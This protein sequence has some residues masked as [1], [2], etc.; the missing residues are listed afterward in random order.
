MQRDK[1]K[2]FSIFHFNL[3]YSSLDQSRIPE[4]I[5]RCYWPLLELVE[6]RYFPVGIEA[7][8]YTLN[9]IQEFDPT[10][11]EKFQQLLSQKKCEF[12]GSG[13]VQL[14]GPLVPAEMN[15][16]NQQLGLGAYK[17]IIEQRPRIALVNEQ[18]FSA[19]MVEHYKDAG[20]E[21]IFMD[22]DN[23][24]L[25]HPQWN[26]MWRYFP[27]IATNEGGS[28]ITVVWSNSIA[29]QKFQRYAHGELSLEAYM[30]FIR[31]HQHE[32]GGCLALYGNDAEVFDFRPGRFHTE[33][34]LS[35]H[36]EWERI[37]TLVDCLHEDTC[38]ELVLPS[39]V[40]SLETHALGGQR[41]NLAS[42]QFP[43]PVKKQFKYNV[44]RWAVS[45]RDDLWLNT[46]CHRM[47]GVLKQYEQQHG[48]HKHLWQRLCQL[49]ASDLRT[50]CTE[51]KWQ[52]AQSELNALGKQ[53]LSKL[54]SQNEGEHEQPWVVLS[55]LKTAGNVNVKALDDNRFIEIK[56]NG[57]T[58]CLSR[59]RGLTIK[60]LAFHQHQGKAA[61]GTLEHGYFD[62]IDLGADY[63]SGG[64]VME[65]PGERLRITDLHEVE[66]L[67]SVSEHALKIKC[68]IATSFG[69]IIKSI[70]I[71][72]ASNQIV[73]KY[74]FPGW[75]RPV[76]SVR[77]ATMTLRPELF[78]NHAEIRC[79]NGGEQKERFV[80]T[81]ECDHTRAVSS[82][83]SARSGLG[84]SRG[85]VDVVNGEGQG[86]RLRWNPE[87][88]AAFPMLL[89]QK[90][91]PS[92][93][94]RLMFSLAE[95]DDTFRSEGK[96]LSFELFI[97]L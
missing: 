85:E 91:K 9:K 65:L 81:Q 68:N 32:H 44:S 69:D 96:L 56:T 83:I 58:L 72:W 79:Y 25:G 75:Q 90:S 6:K 94:T 12:I 30:S 19:S 93:L 49:W 88:C 35:E 41:L 10:W 5:E 80:L 51:Q 52:N 89:H 55:D 92:D 13:Y 57:V 76:G 1:L 50:H 53:C 97:G 22:W 20:Y 31:Q 78:G 61:V 67:F 46:Q 59:L 73:L 82:L 47:L 87:Q 48:E 64:V 45:G 43:I 60:Y 37:A 71:N 18:A 4:V 38:S 54:N 66:P 33:A 40:L 62:S 28:E 14:I 17:D 74:D 36:V 15:S 3:A 24:F 95:L 7:S 39:E 27:Q 86:I 84:A 34:A 63:Y 16:K 8:A 70:T 21:A 26:T 42:L 29:F 2:L 11:L 77:L 23:P